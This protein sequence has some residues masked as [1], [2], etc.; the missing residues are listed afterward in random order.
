MP[1]KIAKLTSF[2]KPKK[3]KASSVK[4]GDTVSWS[5]NKDPDPPSVVHGI[6]V[7]VNSEKKE[8]TMQV[9]AIMEDG[10]H[11]KTDRRVTMPI[12]KLQVIKPIK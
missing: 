9:W 6:V 5:I 3:S 1:K 4:V 2:S 11:K 12:S 8:A 7:S 10:S